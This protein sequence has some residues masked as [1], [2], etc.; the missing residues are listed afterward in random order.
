[1][2]F[3]QNN[4]IIPL[5]EIGASV[6][7]SVECDSFNMAGYDH[8]T[9][10]LQFASTLST[11]SVPVLTMETGSSDSGDQAD[12]TFHY[13]LNSS[14]VTGN[15]SADVLAADATASTL[16]LTSTTYAGHML[17]LEIDQDELPTASKTYQWV[18]VDMTP[19]TASVTFAA[20]AILSNP[21]YAKAVM[22]GAL[23]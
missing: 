20:Y 4:L 11:A 1:M 15:V 14:S 16:T 19:G 23:V 10:I 6:G 18:T 5:V 22:P 9:I 8:A 13:R 3:T 7:D 2:L 21:R 17:I 12:A